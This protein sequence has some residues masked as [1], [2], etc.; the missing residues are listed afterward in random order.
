M[1]GCVKDCFPCDELGDGG[2]D[3][4]GGDGGGV[5]F[6]CCSNAVILGLWLDNFV[7]AAKRNIVKGM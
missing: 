5:L 7:L 3:G 2:G 1:L 6:C 4:G